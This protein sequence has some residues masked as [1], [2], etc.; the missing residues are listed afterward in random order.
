MPS[1]QLSAGILTPPACYANEQ[2]RLS[3]YVGA[4]SATI[5]GGVQWEVSQ[6]APTDLTNYWL[7]TDSNN[8]PLEA[9]KWSIQDAAW[10]RWLNEVTFGV[11]AGGSNALTL[12]NTPAF[13]SAE[14]YALGRMFA[15]VSNQTVSGA[16]TLAVDGFTAQ[17]VKKNG[18]VALTGGEIVSGQTV[19]VMYDGVNFQVLNPVFVPASRST[20]TL[21]DSN[22]GGGGLIP[23]PTGTNA[24][25]SQAHGLGGVPD[26]VQWFLVC[27]V[28]NPVS[29]AQ[30]LGY[31]I[32][33]QILLRSCSDV[34][35]QNNFI[36]E[37]SDSTTCRLCAS[38][39]VTYIPWVPVRDSNSAGGFYGGGENRWPITP[40]EWKLRLVAIRYV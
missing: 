14:A 26:I 10:I 5:S 37:E 39:W 25:V 13:T 28:A 8:R 35:D 32:G 12:T 16:T 18:T 40:A 1:I 27:Q 11:C 20:A 22:T 21:Y 38:N 36:G 2:Y 7:R 31:N 6:T 15:F 3:A 17:P 30:A 19:L 23:V 29:G 34:T 33:D 9:L 4:M 24:V